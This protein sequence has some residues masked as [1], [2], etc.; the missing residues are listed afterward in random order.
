MRA[1]RLSTLLPGEV[2]V[3]AEDPVGEQPYLV[4]G[5]ESALGQYLDFYGD[6]WDTH[7]YGYI[8]QIEQLMMKFAEID[9]RSLDLNTLNADATGIADFEHAVASIV[10]NAMEAQPD[11]TSLSGIL[12]TVKE[13]EDR[14]GQVISMRA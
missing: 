12:F 9:G 13:A 7:K 5:T 8:K 14:W 10:T 1:A 6:G 2:Q 3:N 4:V 11:P